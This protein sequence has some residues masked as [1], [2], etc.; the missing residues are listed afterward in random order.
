VE[1]S[2][3]Q[4]I[5]A[6]DELRELAGAAGVP[7]VSVDAEPTA[8]VVLPSRVPPGSLAYVMFTSGST[9]RAKGV[10]VTQ[11]AVV[12]LAA[13][14]RFGS[15]AH[16]RV[17]FHSPHSFDAATYEVWVP[18]LNGGCVVVAEGEVSV[19]VVRDAVA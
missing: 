9:G 2:G 5:V 19:P 3:A 14:E 11:G 6:D 10:A 8:D 17:L 4:L 1:D 16:G 7:L 18:L 13:D 12:A 15:G